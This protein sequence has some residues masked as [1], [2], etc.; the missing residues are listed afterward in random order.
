MQ[1]IEIKKLLAN[2]GAVPDCP[3]DRFVSAFHAQM[4]ETSALSQKPVRSYWGYGA[5]AASLILAFGIFFAVQ[6]EM[7]PINST[8]ETI[9]ASV[10]ETP[11]DEFA[12]ELIADVYIEEVA[13]TNEL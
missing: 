13:Q 10:S 8:Q 12:A 6:N 4:D 5:I 11:A 2:A 3:T 9:T 7:L 1:D